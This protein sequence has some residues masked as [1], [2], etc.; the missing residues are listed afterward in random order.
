MRTIRSGYAVCEECQTLIYE[1]AYGGCRNPGVQHLGCPACSAGG[2]RSS[3]GVGRAT[4]LDADGY[5]LPLVGGALEPFLPPAHQRRSDQ[6]GQ[7]RDQRYGRPPRRHVRRSD[8]EGWALDVGM[9]PVGDDHQRIGMLAERNRM[10]RATALRSGSSE[11][12]SGT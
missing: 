7:R 2:K 11:R 12:L 9:L 8:G 4:R 3:G 1:A 6:R 5:A 10:M